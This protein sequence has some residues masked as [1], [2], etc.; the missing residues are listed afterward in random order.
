MDPKAEMD[1]MEFVLTTW[2]KAWHTWPKP[3]DDVP[4]G[5]PMLIWSLMGPGRWT[6]TSSPLR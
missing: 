3:T 6:K 5:D 4:M 1:L 2:G